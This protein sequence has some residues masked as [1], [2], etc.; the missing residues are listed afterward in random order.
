M[1]EEVEILVSVDDEVDSHSILVNAGDRVE[2]IVEDIARELGAPLMDICLG[3]TRIPKDA[4]FAD[5]FEPDV[6]YQARSPS[7][8][9]PGIV[10]ALS[11]EDASSFVISVEHAATLLMSMGPGRWDW[12]DLEAVLDMAPS[13]TDSAEREMA[14]WEDDLC[15]VPGG[16]AI[17]EAHERALKGLLCAGGRNLTDLAMIADVELTRQARARGLAMKAVFDEVLGRCQRE[18]CL[19]AYDAVAR[20]VPIATRDEQ[21]AAK[22]LIR[23]VRASPA[24]LVRLGFAC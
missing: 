6:V 11:C 18:W 20:L 15:R 23:Y 14:D 16:E 22:L 17:E 24:D 12:K 21:I 19:A 9:P 10:R 4:V 1:G 8:L 3:E 7:Y 2:T 5:Y 13:E